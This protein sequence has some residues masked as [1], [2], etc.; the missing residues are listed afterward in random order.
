MMMNLRKMTK[1]K[2]HKNRYAFKIVNKN[3]LLQ[4]T[5]CLTVYTGLL[6][7]YFFFCFVDESF[8]VVLIY[9][10]WVSHSFRYIFLAFW[11]FDSI[12]VL[13]FFYWFRGFFFSIFRTPTM[14]MTRTHP[15]I[16]LVYILFIH[17]FHHHL[18]K[19]TNYMTNQ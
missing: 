3:Y 7:I 2:L 16:Y 13:N 11:L 10:T 18:K 14:T 12:I 17:F 4:K 8:W 1:K 19:Q 5:I 9:H 6:R 15:R